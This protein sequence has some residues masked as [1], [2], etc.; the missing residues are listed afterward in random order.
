MQASV[1]ESMSLTSGIGALI[2]SLTIVY[3][4]IC[5]QIEHFHIHAIFLSK[6]VSQ[7]IV[8][9]QLKQIISNT[10]QYALSCQ[11]FP[12]F[13]SFRNYS[14]ILE[15][16]TEFENK[17]KNVS[18]IPILRISISVLV[19]LLVRPYSNT[20]KEQYYSCMLVILIRV[21]FVKPEKIKKI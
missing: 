20:I 19:F 12:K 11:S 8:S 21:D 13:K 5:M 10:N 2:M 17:P 1:R 6:F 4:Y 15:I 18:L 7:E 3:I 16:E 9:N 14:N